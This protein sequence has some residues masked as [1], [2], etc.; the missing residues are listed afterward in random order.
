[1]TTANEMEVYAALG[2]FPPSQLGIPDA[3]MGLPVSAKDCNAPV[4]G[5]LDK[6]AAREIGLERFLFALGIFKGI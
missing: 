3:V 1:M 4:K 5:C 6:V 2:E